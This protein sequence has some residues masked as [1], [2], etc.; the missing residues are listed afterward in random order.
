MTRPTPT[1]ILLAGCLAAAIVAAALPIAAHAEDAAPNPSYT[2]QGGTNEGGGGRQGGGGG[3]QSGG[4]GTDGAGT[5]VGGYLPQLYRWFLGFVGIAALFAF[6]MGGVLYMFAGAN[7]T[8]T[9]QARKWITNGVIGLLVAASSYLFLKTINP[10][11]V[12][13]FD[14]EALIKANLPTRP[15][16]SGGPSGPE[17]AP[18]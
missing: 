15:A 18:F 6:V 12:G 7:I 2:P 10:E 3:S 16:S 11:L 14:I 8:T 1:A 13:G 5:P 17:G 4:G 9:A